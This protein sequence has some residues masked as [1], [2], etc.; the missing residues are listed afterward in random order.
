MIKEKCDHKKA[1]CK[2]TFCCFHN[3]SKHH[4]NKWPMTVRYDR[5]GMT[6]RLCKHGV[7]HPDPDSLAWMNRVGRDDD[8]IHGCDGCCS[9]QGR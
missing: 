6:E 1:E 9:K 8:G 3:P 2:G 5:G 4:M 7:G